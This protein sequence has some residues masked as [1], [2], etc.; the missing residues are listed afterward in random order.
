MTKA[1]MIQGAGSNVGKSV[2][3]PG[4]AA[5]WSNAAI[6]RHRSSR[7]ICPIMPP[8]PLTVER[9]AAR[10]RYKPSPADGPRLSI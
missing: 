1:I 6:T 3:W 9:S 8:S 2:W 10:K 7:K 4:F 5:R